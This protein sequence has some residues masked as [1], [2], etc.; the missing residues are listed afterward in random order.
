MQRTCLATI[1]A[2]FISTSLYAA[3]LN[4]LTKKN[5][6]EAGNQKAVVI[7]HVNW[8][9]YWKCG[10]LDNAQMEALK[11]SKIQKDETKASDATI[12]LE[13]P[14]KLNAKDSFVPYVLL[15]E[16]GDYALSSFD[17]KVARSRSDIGHLKGD[18]STLMKDK[19][20]IGG[21]FTVGAGEIVYIGHFG[22]DCAKEP[23][24]WRYYI[25]GKKDFERYIAGFREEFPFVQD[26]PVQ[27]RLFSTTMFGQEYSLH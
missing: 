20:P 6:T 21:T 13:T 22:L 15:M 27:F 25:E 23:F 3:E 10:G 19:K 24:L 17:V 8:G 18:E 1:L 2:V 26:K 14:S 7:L 4:E 11:F 9:R 16:P 5:Y 12:S